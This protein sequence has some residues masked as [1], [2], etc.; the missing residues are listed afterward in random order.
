MSISTPP[1]LVRVAGAPVWSRQSI[2]VKLPLA[3]ALVLLVLGSAMAIVSYLEVRHT[4]I[5]IAA[6]RLEGA[7]NQMAA[8]LSASARQRVAAVQQLMQRPEVRAILRERSSASAAAFESPAKAYLGAAALF[9]NVEVWDAS[10][11][12]VF[13]MGAPFEHPAGAALAA[14]LKELGGTTATI[15]TLRREGDNEAYPIGGRIVADGQTLGYVVDRRRISNPSQT[16]Q[17]IAMLTGLIGSEATIVVGNGDGGEWSDLSR[18]VRGVP[19]AR[20]GTGRLWDYERPGAPRVLAWASAIDATPWLVAI[21][22]PRGVVLAPADRLIQR[23]LGITFALL[24]VAAAIGWALSH[25]LITPLRHVTETAEAVAEMRHV[26]PI[27][28]D[29]QDE[30]GRLAESFNT[31]AERVE[32]A[33]EELEHRVEARTEELRALNRELE[34]FSYS[35]SH[36]LRAPLRAIVGFVQ[37]LEEDH[38][39]AFNPDARRALDRVKVNA[40][41]MGQLIDD[42]LAFAQIGRVPLTRQR[43]ELNHLARSVAEEALAAAERP[44]ELVIE[45]LPPCLGEPVLLKQVFANLLSNAVKFTARTERPV[46]T[47]GSMTNADTIYFVRDNGAGFDERF[48]DKLFGV[49]QRLHRTVEFEGTGVGLAIVQ[50]IINRHGGRVWAEGRVNQGATFYFT[51]PAAPITGSGKHRVAAH[52]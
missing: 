32:N 36:D 52:Q 40:T 12:K 17:T 21:E 45:P 20:E 27:D 3:F 44:I 47:V 28:T 37:I 48:A 7:A 5:A 50:R 16:R 6:E 19:I 34:S 43:V 31:M 46:I 24:V 35:V 22:F 29:R 2:A 18:P 11:A 33:R 42:L 1:R 26:A 9:G 38:S 41:R 4:V 25:R 39:A 23:F 13:A 30:I 15:G 14:Y 10:G 8:V 51:L 49:F